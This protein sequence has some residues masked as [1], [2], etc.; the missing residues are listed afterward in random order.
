MPPIR[1]GDGT[2]VVAKGVGEV[3]AGDGRV[4]FSGNAIPDSEADSKLAHRWYFG[5]TDPFVDQIGSDDATNNGTTEVTGSWV[6]GA[7]REGDGS[8]DY[9]D[10]TTL[11]SFGSDMDNSDGFAL[12]LS[13]ET[14][15]ADGS[16]FGT[17]NDD[18]ATALEASWRDTTG[19]VFYIRDEDIN[20][21]EFEWPDYEDFEDGSPHRIVYNIPDLSDVS[22]W[23]IWADQ[24]NQSVSVVTDE[25]PDNTADFQYAFTIFASNLRG[26]IERHADTILDDICIF[27]QSLTN[28]E[29]E[30]Y[31]NP[32][33]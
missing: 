1:R 6:D 5:E 32:W 30:S 14:S 31:T 23:E 12:A 19:S 24:S 28:S 18:S 11:G 2:E 15:K 13:V 29:I 27:N 21:G 33:D 7:A 22:T 26:S 20:T 4:F 3:R 17:Y 16:L 9:V 8:D 10:H 25:S